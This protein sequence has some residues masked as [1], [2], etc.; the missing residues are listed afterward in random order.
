MSGGFNP[1]SMVSQLAMGVM[2][3][4]TSLIA[5]LAMQIV[6]QVAK[7]VIGQIG[8][9]L[10]LPKPAIDAALGAFDAASGNAA[11]AAQNFAGAA[12]GSVADILSAFGGQQGA[13]PASIGQATREIHQ[14]TQELKSVAQQLADNRMKDATAGTDEDGNSNRGK[15][16]MMR[17]GG[18]VKATGAA[19]TSAAGASTGAYTA[20][21]SGESFLMRLAMALGSA[22]DHKMDEQL[23]QAQTIDEKAQKGDGGDK[24]QVTQDGAKLTALGQ[25]ISILSNA[26]NTALKTIGEAVSTLARKS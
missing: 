1:I 15:Q 24:S 23:K 21:G 20:P 19:G 7:E 25:E 12:G 18:G 17:G 2:T 11:G 6:S 22:V 5:Q 16:A 9:Q 14:A 3:G 8:Q 26:L 13:S 10:G 4:G